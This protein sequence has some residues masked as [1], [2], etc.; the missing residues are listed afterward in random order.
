MWKWGYLHVCPLIHGFWLPLWYLHIFL[1]DIFFTKLHQLQLALAGKE[2]QVSLFT[3]ELYTCIL[4]LTHSL[5]RINDLNSVNRAQIL[6]CMLRSIDLKI[7]PNRSIEKCTSIAR[8][9]TKI[10]RMLIGLW[11]FLVL[12]NISLSINLLSMSQQRHVFV[13]CHRPIGRSIWRHQRVIRS[14]N[15]IKT[16]DTIVQWK[17]D[18]KTNN[19]RQNTTQ[20]TK[21]WSTLKPGD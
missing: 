16:D 21:D 10:V 18:K 12:C 9:R 2:T 6:S 17:S 19:G 3:C 14:C 15:S 11:L 8:I 5:W 7:I 13:G 4:D 1:H 20:K